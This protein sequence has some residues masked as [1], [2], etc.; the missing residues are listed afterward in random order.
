MEVVRMPNKKIKKS[1]KTEQIPLEGT[2]PQDAKSA[3]SKSDVPKDW[4][5]IGQEGFKVKEQLDTVVQ[6]KK[7]RYAPRFML[8]AK[9]SAH[10]VF[11]DE[12]NPFFI[13]EH[14]LQ[15]GKRWGNYVTCVKE[16]Q[17]CD[18]CDSG[19]KS[20]YTGYL[21]VIDRREFINSTTGKKVQNRK[22]L[23]PAKG[24][25]IDRIKVLKQ[26]YGDLTGMEFKITR[27]TGDDPNCGT[28]FDYT[29]KYRLSGEQAQP[30][31]YKKVLKPATNEELASLG[32][33]RNVIGEQLPITPS[34]EPPGVSD[35]APLGQL[36]DLI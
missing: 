25:T 19:K 20:T 3:Q 14:N 9:E 30:Y 13:Y 8:K 10:V 36:E 6:M 32:I 18:V 34:P 11:V 12:G 4:F 31:D 22:V 24:S 21:T 15:I 28:D 1:K 29:K 26:K 35:S 23:Y 5:F 17:A 33:H 16:V 2:L 27:F 7:E